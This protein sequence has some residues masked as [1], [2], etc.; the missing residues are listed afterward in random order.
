MH[1][2][3][4]KAYPINTNAKCMI[5]TK[6]PIMSTRL[7]INAIVVKTVSNYKYLGTI[8]NDELDSFTRIQKRIEV[9]RLSSKI[10]WITL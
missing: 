7:R 6:K 1:F 8:L 4:D 2:I 3:F 9:A 10:T 5:V